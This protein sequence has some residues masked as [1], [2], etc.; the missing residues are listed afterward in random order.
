MK[1][2]DSGQPPHGA[3]GDPQ[4]AKRHD[5]AENQKA[6]AA[7]TRAATTMPTEHGPAEGTDPSLA[8]GKELRRNTASAT[9]TPPRTQPYD[10]RTDDRPSDGGGH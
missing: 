6:S 5:K 7:K 2:Q 3:P 1:Q 9:Q 8:H 4:R 10:D